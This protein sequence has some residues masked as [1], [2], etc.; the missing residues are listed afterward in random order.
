MCFLTNY[1]ANKYSELLN[2]VTGENFRK[3]YLKARHRQNLLKTTYKTVFFSS[4][5]LDF[6]SQ[7]NRIEYR[8]GT[9]ENPSPENCVAGGIYPYEYFLL[10]SV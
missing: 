5:L 4:L 10:M 2:P 1:G 9:S 8:S 6:C 7:G 3:H